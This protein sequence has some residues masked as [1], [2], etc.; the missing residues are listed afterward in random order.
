M[1]PFLLLLTTQPKDKCTKNAVDISPAESKSFPSESSQDALS[2]K[3]HT[4]QRDPARRNVTRSEGPVSDAPGEQYNHSREVASFLY[5]EQEAVVEF[6][7]RA[8]RVKAR[9]HILGDY[10]GG[11]THST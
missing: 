2:Y 11:H 1:K 4:R 9:G 8:C 5:Q 7:V 10:L 6:P 3:R